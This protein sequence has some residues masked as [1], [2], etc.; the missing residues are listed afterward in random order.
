MENRISAAGIHSGNSSKRKILHLVVCCALLP[1]VAAHGQPGPA[2]PDKLANAIS[3]VESGTFSN[4]AVEQIAEAHAV[5]EIP[6]LEKQF[7]VA[8]EEV[9]L[10]SVI[11]SALV[12]L[13]DNNN[14]YWNYLVE[15]A[16]EAINSGLPFPIA[17]DSQGVPIRGQLSPEFNAWIKAHNIPP[18]AVGDLAFS[19]PG[20]VISL[21]ETGDPRGIPLLRRALQSP[22]PFM[23]LFAAKGLALI[24]DK[25]SIPLIIAVCKRSYP[26]EAEAIAESLIYFDDA[27]AQSAA[28]LYLPK[29]LSQ[30]LRQA[31]ANG[32]TPFY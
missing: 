6:V 10:K 25:A 32:K 13:G 23:A 24:H 15:Q 17:R 31:R 3:Q 26:D 1:C 19:L 21:A 29:E 14:I 12:R 11:A 27:E 7:V 5:Q 28:D 30:A 18:E 4:Y 8:S 2:Q 16:T 22:N 9:N 20:K